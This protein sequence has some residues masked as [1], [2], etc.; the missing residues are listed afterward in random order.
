MFVLIDLVKA[1]LARLLLIVHAFVAVWR[2]VEYK[3]DQMYWLLL[4]SL[5]GTLIDTIY[6]LW[7]RKG[8]EWKW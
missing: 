6:I 5:V 7:R 3:G 8:E 4:L 1:I 2:V